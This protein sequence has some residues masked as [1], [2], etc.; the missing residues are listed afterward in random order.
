MTPS[1]DTNIRATLEARLAEIR[2]RLEEFQQ[3]LR[4]PEDDDIEEVAAEADE[5][6]VLERLARATQDEMR[7][8]LVALQRIE[9]GDYGTCDTCGKKIAEKRL[10]A[11]PETSL[12]RECAEK[13]L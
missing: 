13:T 3:V 8:I 1:K 5:D 9:K 2:L 11:L 12:C 10:R 6:M 7:Q 4:E